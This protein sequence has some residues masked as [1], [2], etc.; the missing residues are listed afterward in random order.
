[1][2]LCRCRRSS[3]FCPG[4][5]TAAIR[6]TKEPVAFEDV[7]VYFTDE[8]WALLDPRQKT[9]YRNVMFENYESVTSLEQLLS[10]KPVLISWLEEDRDKEWL[11]QSSVEEERLTGDGTANKIKWEDCFQLEDSTS[12]EEEGEDHEEDKEIESL[13][14]KCHENISLQNDS[15][16]R[17][18]EGHSELLK[19]H[20]YDSQSDSLLKLEPDFLL[21]LKFYLRTLFSVLRSTLALCNAY[22]V[23]MRRRQK[24]RAHIG[25]AFQDHFLR[26]HTVSRAL[27]R[28]RTRKRAALVALLDNKPLPRR[29][30]VSPATCLNWWENFMHETTDDAKWI[31]QFRM[32]RGTLF[33]I[34]E[35]LR[36]KLERQRTIM[37]EAISV[38]KRVAIVVWWL[39]NLERYREV[40]T[41]FGIGRSTV[42]DI[43]LEVCFAIELLLAPQM[44]CMGD[45]QKI[46]EG[47]RSLGFPHCIGA[48]DKTHV[49]IVTL[50]GQADETVSRKKVFPF[51]VQTI[52]DHT[53]RFIYI[54]VNRNGENVFSNSALCQ[55]MDEGTFIP[56]NPTVTMGGVQVPPLILADDSYPLR[57]WLMTPYEDQPN[58][59]ERVYNANFNKC[60]SVIEQ[61]MYRLRGRW[62]CLT[63]RLPL[64]EENVVAVV[65][66]CVVL[67]N[68]CESKGHVLQEG[69]KVPDQVLLPE[70]EEEVHLYN[71]RD[72]EEGEAIRKAITDFMADQT[73]SS[74][75]NEFC[76]LERQEVEGTL[77]KIPKIPGG[78]ESRFLESLNKRSTVIK[79][80]QSWEKRR[81]TDVCGQV[82]ALA[83]D[84]LL[85]HQEPK[86]K[87]NNIINRTMS[88]KSVEFSSTELRAI[89][90]F[91]F[92]QKKTPKEIHECM[93]QTLSDKCPSYS[94]VKKWCA[95]FQQ[96][97]FETEDAAR[98]GRPSTVSTPEMVERVH[99]LILADQRISAKTIAET[100][101]ISR[102]RIGF[103]IH[104]QLSMQKLLAK[105]VPKCL[106]D[107]Q[108]RNRVD[109]SKLILQHFEQS[110]DNFL[111]QLVTV[112]ETWLHHYGLETKQ[113][114][115]QWRHS[116]SPW[117]KKF[118]T[119]RSAGK[120]MAIVFWDKEGI[121]MTNCVQKNQTMNAEYYSNLLCQLKET[122]KGK[123]QGKLQ[124]DNDQ[125]EVEDKEKEVAAT[126][127][128]ETPACVNG[129]RIS[130][131][132][133]I[134][135]F[136]QIPEEKEVAES[137]K[138]ANFV[139]EKPFKCFD[140]G[141]H[142][143]AST[144]LINHKR[145]HTGE[146]PYTCLSCG[147]SFTEKGNLLKHHRIHTGEKP[148]KCSDCGKAFGISSQLISHKRVH[149]G[150]K[151][152]ECSDCGKGFCTSSQLVCHN[153]VHTG[154]KPYECSECG[155]TFSQ[156]SYL[157][158]HE[159]T[160]TG[161]KPFKCSQCGKWFSHR[162][163]CLRHEKIHTGEKPHKCPDCG[164]GFSQ[165]GSLI[166]HQRIH[167]GE[168]PFECS[169]CGKSFNDRSYFI[170]HRRTH[171]GEKPYKCTD[172]GKSFSRTSH[173][174][175]HR[176]THTGEK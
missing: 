100:L 15:S 98:S 108:K 175:A 163:D 11:I 52:T 6:P 48:M 126:I 67:H 7:A 47:F 30:W 38:E 84:F 56:G 69:V 127:P 5:N 107:D 110:S 63:G 102:E 119:Q 4:V 76:F 116:D 122:L 70:C 142:F 81:R 159:R 164:K 153:R 59:R 125:L 169:E 118:K 9:L 73:S 167:T 104:E 143:A 20:S 151:P 2:D 128:L 173:L 172:C 165:K 113:Q 27:C 17:L 131:K 145:V 3:A 12:E 55:A 141:K 14:Q 44:I 37:R 95:N 16:E 156:R 106:N 10:F 29:W 54:E 144:H 39:S 40:A 45:H 134:G 72:V 65:T 22:L 121:L 49:A 138:R 135:K 132:E 170:T 87:D 147:K 114:F 19:D 26:R 89:M 32:S 66:A 83:E 124:K 50:A 99:D 64:A 46:M 78:N 53:G 123:R 41:Q 171:T 62:Q 57:K 109:T 92:L 8:E 154:E 174:T 120:V 1:M 58:E 88:A 160:H 137:V 43:V 149:T 148:Y 111:E 93:M 157:V 176:K 129:S 117:R 74:W 13:S 36:P 77:N 155:K 96:G 51:Q 91:L 75:G 168:K 94:T 25:L 97:D 35:V 90:K 101:D 21:L 71:E 68:I 18:E 158:G 152:Y 23:S 103:I 61:A 105:W 140:C 34:A 24:R 80:M 166:T 130:L 85:K 31:E 42:G 28:R 162:S 161:E 82:V 115:L 86:R 33:E 79:E 139:M 136:F 150:E 112:D 60:R 146:K 133:V